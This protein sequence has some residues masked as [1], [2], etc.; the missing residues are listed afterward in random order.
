MKWISVEDRLPESDDAV[1]ICQAGAANEYSYPYTFEDSIEVAF[2][3]HPK[4]F[5]EDWDDDRFG[6]DDFLL[7]GV[8][9]WMPLP[10]PPN[11]E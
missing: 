10:E 6:K 7:E 4:W 3:S 2:F 8:T 9:H 11:G 1:L 5:L